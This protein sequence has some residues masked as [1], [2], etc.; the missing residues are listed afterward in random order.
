MQDEE[1]PPHILPSFM[2]AARAFKKDSV[3]QSV[4]H[5]VLPSQQRHNHSD[6]DNQ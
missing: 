4:L 5:H 6:I 1:R 3:Q 2:Q